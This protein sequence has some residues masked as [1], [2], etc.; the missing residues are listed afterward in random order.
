MLLADRNKGGYLLN[1][2][3]ERNLEKQKKLRL[4]KEELET[5]LLILQEEQVDIENMELIK[6]FRRRKIS[7]DEFLEL[8]RR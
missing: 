3:L 1:N 5:Q 6:E 2:K 7:L 4:K 8:V